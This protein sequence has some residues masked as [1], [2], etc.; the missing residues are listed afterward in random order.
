[1]LKMGAVPAGDSPQAFEAF[2]ARERQRLAEVI[3]KSGI[4]LSE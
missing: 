3:T 1:V 2:M 4:V